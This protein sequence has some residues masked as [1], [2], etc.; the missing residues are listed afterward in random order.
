MALQYSRMNHR[1]F[2]WNIEVTSILEDSTPAIV[3]V[4]IMPTRGGR[5]RA[6]I[7]MDH[8]FT[9]L[10]PGLNTITRDEMDA[11]HLSSSRWSLTDLQRIIMNC[12][13][14]RREF[15]WG[16]RGWPRH[17]N[18]PRGTESGMAWTMVVMVSQVLPQDR[19]R[20]QNWNSNSQAAWSYCGVRFGQ[21][22][23]SRPLG[24]PTDRSFGDIE[25]LVGGRRNWAVVPVRIVHG[26]S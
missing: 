17:L 13:I 20:V 26:S 5:N 2:T 22:P 12:Q 18:V 4:F 7:H 24:F 16:G 3:K 23:D 8:F 1:Q 14:S 21:V 25:N 19:R 9:T 10:N 15:S 6:T 11:P